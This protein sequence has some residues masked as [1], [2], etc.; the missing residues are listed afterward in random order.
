MDQMVTYLPGI[1][2]AYS[3]FLLS[4]MSPGPNVLAVM[5]TSMSIGRRSGVSLAMGVA[6]GSFIWAI[7]TAAGLS[8]VI[9]SYAI[10][11]TVIKII[12]GGSVAKLLL[13]LRGALCLTSCQFSAFASAFSSTV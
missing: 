5:G 2:L 8:A 9:A 11:L 6:A 13:E 12:G 4:I 10:V 3:A 7:L 1:L